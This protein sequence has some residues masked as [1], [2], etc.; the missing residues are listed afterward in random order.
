MTTPGHTILTREILEEG[1]S[2]LGGY[3]YYQME[4]IDVPGI[5]RPMFLPTGWRKTVIGREYPDAVLAEFVGLKDKHLTPAKIKYHTARKAKREAER[6][7]N[8]GA[9]A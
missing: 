5:Q 4:L 6:L 3:T 1:R 2:S 9:P 7:A 8:K